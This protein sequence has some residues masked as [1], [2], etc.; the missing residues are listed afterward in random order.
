M[1]VPGRAAAGCSAIASAAAA[2]AGDCVT[3]S[4][5]APVALAAWEVSIVAASSW[6]PHN[7]GQACLLAGEI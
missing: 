3:A 4:L 6:A 5:A 7:H 2:A 1:K